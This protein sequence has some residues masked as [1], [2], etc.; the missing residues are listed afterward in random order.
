VQ[1][2]VKLHSGTIRAESV[3]G[4]GTSFIVAIPL[5]S[6]HL[7]Q[8]QIVENPE[9]MSTPS[10]ANSFVE[11]ALSWLPDTTETERSRQ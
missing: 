4:K 3:L 1:E 2:L 10:G 6:S 9:P 11:E 8:D 7:S 5:G